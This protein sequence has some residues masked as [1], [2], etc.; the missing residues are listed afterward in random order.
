MNIINTEGTVA[1]SLGRVANIPYLC[2]GLDVENADTVL[3]NTNNA[4]AFNFMAR[5]SV[6]CSYFASQLSNTRNYTPLSFISDVYRHRGVTKPYNSSRSVVCKNITFTGSA[7]IG[8]LDFLTFCTTLGRN[9]I[10]S[11]PGLS[12]FE[13]DFGSP[14]AIYGFGGTI[15]SSRPDTVITLVMYLDNNVVYSGVVA[16]LPKVIADRAEIVISSPV[17]VNSTA[18]LANVRFLSTQLIEYE[19]EVK[20]IVLA[21]IDFTTNRPWSSQIPMAHFDLDEVILPSRI[22]GL[23]HTTFPLTLGMEAKNET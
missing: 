9:I 2:I 7:T 12:K 17:Q 4:E 15:T 21:R 3:A 22:T 11:L 1:R 20:S 5:H 23:L 8:G 16:Q 14:I 10:V 13:F 19:E 18:T 6:S